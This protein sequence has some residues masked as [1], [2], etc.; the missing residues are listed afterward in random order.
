MTVGET[1][2][3]GDS[4]DVCLTAAIYRAAGRFMHAAV[5]FSDHVTEP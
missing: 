2:A 4:V 5:G 3:E 1:H